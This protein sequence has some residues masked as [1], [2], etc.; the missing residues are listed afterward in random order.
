VSKIVALWLASLLIG[1]STLQLWAGGSGLNVVVVVNQS[2]TNSVLL[3]NYYRA[4]RQVP[5]QNVLRI[6]WTGAR[7]EWTVNDFNNTLLNPFLAM[8]VSRQLTNQIDYVVLS[9]DI[10]YRVGDT[11]N[12]FN[13]TTSALFYGFKSDPDFTAPCEI[14]A[15]STNL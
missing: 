12:G 3:G 9:M 5:P 7:N 2:S 4:Q 8:L 15:G 14:T 1:I 10:P 13:S 6:N 11:T